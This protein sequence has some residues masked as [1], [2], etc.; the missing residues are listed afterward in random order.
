VANEVLNKLAQQQTKLRPSCRVLSVNWGP[1]DG[2]MVTPSLKKIFENEGIGLIPLKAGAEYLIQEICSSS[3]RPVEAVIQG[4]PSSFAPSIERSIDLENYPVLKSH[5]LGGQAVLPMAVMVE[6]LAHGAMHGNP[7]L[8]FY[9]FNDLSV[10]KGIKLNGKGSL[11]LRILAGKSVKRENVFIVPTEL[12][13][14]V[15]GRE[16]MNAKAEVI[17]SANLPK[18]ERTI[19]ETVFPPYHRQNG[20]LYHNFLFHGP[21][22]QGIEWIDGCS[23]QGMIGTSRTAPP[24]SAW[25][26]HPLRSSW[27]T[28]PLAL[29]CS[30][31]LMCVWSFEHQ[32]AFSLPSFAGRYRQFKLFPK[33]KVRIV[34]QVLSRSKNK[35]LANIE[36]IDPE[37]A[38]IAR[39]ENYECVTDPLLN[40]AFAD[41]HLT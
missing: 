33:D 6:L 11:E 26:K 18:G 28:D 25:V 35:A 21:D 15:N 29:D 5:V 24:P 40:K 37:G 7:G 2:G 8:A 30:F 9:G 4:K 31:Q 23:D 27:I 38:L 19:P 17:L 10:F 1:W 12:R 32:G 34:I 3:D 14:S 39:M 16:F 13:S 22:L 41:N 36:F 20:N